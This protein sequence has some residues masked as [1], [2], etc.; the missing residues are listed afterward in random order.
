MEEKRY[1]I[2]HSIE[3]VIDV[4]QGAPIQR[5]MVAQ[6]TVVQVMNRIPV[7]HLS[8][9]RAMKFLIT[10]AG[11]QFD[12]EHSLEGRLKE[13]NEHDREAADFLNTAFREAVDHYGYNP[14]APYMGHLENLQKY[15]H[16]TGSN[17]AFQRM[18]Y[19]ELEQSLNDDLIRKIYP[20]LHL[21]LLHALREILL[22]PERPKDTVTVR[23]ERAAEFAL[24]NNARG[25]SAEDSLDRYVEWLQRHDNFRQ[26]MASAVKENFN[27][28]DDY[29]QETTRRAYAELMESKDPAVRYFASTLDVL[30][31]QPRDAIPDVEWLGPE[32]LRFG[33]VSTPG[34]EV[35]GFIE[36]GPDKLWY[37]TP[38]RN[39]L[40]RVSAKAQT[41]T[42]A[43]CHLA[44]LLT[45]SAR[46]IVG[47]EEGQARIV[48]EEHH[49][50][51][52]NYGRMVN[53]WE[54]RA[55]TEA[56]EYEV[57]FWDAEHELN[58]G[59]PIRLE[60]P[61]RN[62]PGLLHILEGTVTRVRD[63][64]VTVKGRNYIAVEK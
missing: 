48:G 12:E 56:P 30:P 5:D 16:E 22:N 19:W 58:D 60:V 1:I 15:M 42:D 31:S 45:W 59:R 21:E 4:L 3:D 53:S 52:R 2:Q 33:K 7:A 54:D 13:L 35:L 40:V 27:I 36:R 23:A 49:L 24:T 41:P 37:I 29:A 50:F 26:A 32:D 11:G 20:S 64:K 38:S 55:N 34:G 63:H 43:R 17:A 25:T 61:R 9:E 10:K 57:T 8:I 44:V 28:G 46:V 39:G 62:P 51:K 47:D 14:K 18:R 6:I